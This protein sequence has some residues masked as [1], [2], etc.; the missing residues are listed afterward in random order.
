M[1]AKGSLAVRRAPPSTENPDLSSVMAAVS[2]TLPVHA[3]SSNVSVTLIFM[4]APHTDL[5][6]GG[7]G[8]G[9]GVGLG[10]GVGGDF[11]E[12]GG[13]GCRAVS[14]RITRSASS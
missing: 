7:G 8:V 9:V 10:R 11:P 14:S 5:G 12:N 6:R 3:Q 1:S 13:P 2:P 4:T